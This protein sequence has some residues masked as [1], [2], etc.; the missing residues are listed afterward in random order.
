[1]TVSQTIIVNYY[2]SQVAGA[3]TVRTKE[4]V[5]VTPLR[6]TLRVLSKPNALVAV[7]KGMRAVKRLLQQNP[8]V[9]TG[10]AG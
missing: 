4:L 3:L 8:P 2:C 5:Q 9:L 7:S 10:G 6:R 1:M